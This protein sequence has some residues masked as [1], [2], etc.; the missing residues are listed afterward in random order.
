MAELRRI[1][2][3]RLHPDPD[4]QHDWSFNPRWI[5]A[6]MQEGGFD[7]DK[8]G[9]I[10]VTPN[11]NGDFNVFWGRHRAALARESGHGP[12][13]CLVHDEMSVPE[14]HAIKL[15]KDRDQRK[16]RAVETFLNEVGAEQEEAVAIT[17]VVEMNGRRVGKRA[18]RLSDFT[19]IESVRALEG[20]YR[21]GGAELLNAVFEFSDSVEEWRGA[22]GTNEGYWLDGLTH[23]VKDGWPNRLTDASR[24]KLGGLTP[25]TAIKRA[26]GEATLQY[27]GQRY[28]VTALFISETLRKYAGVRAT[29]R[30]RVPQEEEAQA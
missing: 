10:D 28:A 4:V 12:I 6:R 2:P 25:R 14:K 29:P 26:Q 16:V 8:A 30:R 11:G 9:M 22:P 27:V 7:E 1:H 17:E 19:V 18:D 23:A 21:D 24:T 3:D 5:K 15:A 20:I 13:R